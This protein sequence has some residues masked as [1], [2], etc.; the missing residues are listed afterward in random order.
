MS[1]FTNPKHKLNF[2]NKCNA[3]VESS[4]YWRQVVHISRNLDILLPLVTEE[5]GFTTC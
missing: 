2:F 4:T 1:E 5:A 3:P